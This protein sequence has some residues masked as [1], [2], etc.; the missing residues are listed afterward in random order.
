MNARLTYFEDF[1]TG[2]TVHHRRG[3]TIIQ[4]ENV[5]WTLATMNTA[6]G[7]WNVES[8]KDYF[9]GVFEQPLVNGTL[10]LAVAAGLTSEDITGGNC[11]DLGLNDITIKTPVCPGDTLWATSEILE[12]RG[13]PGRDDAGI[14]VY[15]IRAHNQHGQQVCSMVRSFLAKRRSHWT[16][17]DTRFLERHWPA[18]SEFTS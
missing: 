15:R 9:G 10:V 18:F 2:Q 5:R 8:L 14:V 13:A 1:E 6:Q 12:K 16:E 7:H 3:R 11:G 17:K 4:P